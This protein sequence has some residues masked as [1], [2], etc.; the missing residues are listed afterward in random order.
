M[1]VNGHCAPSQ[2]NNTISCLDY[3]LLKKI[4]ETLNKYD[5]NIKVYKTKKRLHDEISKNIKKETECETESCWKSLGIIKN[6]LT[7]KEKEILENSFR[8][9]M[10]EEWK[11]NP[12][13]WLSTI[14][15]DHVMEQYEVGYPKFQYLG[16]NP[17]DF[18]TKIN[19]NTCVS[20]EL[21]NFHIKDIR[22][23]GK[24][25][26]GMVFNTDP[27]NKSG[28]HWFSLFIDLKGVNIKGKP[29]IYYFD[30][31]ASKP[32]DEV[33]KFVERV[34]KQCFEI[35]KDID[36]LFNDI[37]HQHNDTE[38][39]VYCL[40]FLVSMLKGCNFKNYIRNKRND[41]QMEEFR[42][43]FFIKN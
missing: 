7:G 36:F 15:I 14:D 34:Q 40:H 11:D 5:Y 43:F 31:L 21:C 6:E 42:N 2:K 25:S 8:P 28:Q 27:H 35:K 38:C 29:C 30:S 12:N 1:F 4:A 20:N 16:A 32:K 33:V 13:T 18:D 26:L 23:D 17:I 19:K 9:D 24:D 37:K 39:G 22:K 41:K 10:P 3:N